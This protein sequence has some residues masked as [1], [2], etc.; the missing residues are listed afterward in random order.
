[1]SRR[2]VRPSC[3]LRV[4]VEGQAEETFVNQVLAL[5]LYGFGYADISARLLGNARQRMR[6]G[7]V[8]PWP[9]VRNEILNNLKRDAGCFV[10]TMVDYYGLPQA[11]PGR[12]QAAQRPLP[13]R[14]KSVEVELLA[15]VHQ[16]MG[17][18]FNPDRFVPYLML[19]EFEAMLFSDCYRFAEAIGR[20]SLA[21]D[22][23]AIRDQ[24]ANPEEIDDSPRTAPSKRIESL[25]AAYQK[26]LMGTRAA[27]AIGLN[28]IRAACPHFD[29]WLDRLERLPAHGGS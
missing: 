29:A 4:H 21:A 10:T 20:S 26:P 27:Q 25:V 3:R 13:E 7:G 19:H 1:M 28:A 24:F 17:G 23:Q 14:A 5:H 22:F 9:A 8:K 12:N 18:G 15:D 6:R 11:W 2:R 16:R